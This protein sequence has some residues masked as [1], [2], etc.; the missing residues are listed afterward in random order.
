MSSSESFKPQSEKVK[1][2]ITILKKLQELG[3]PINE[4][5]YVMLK[6]KFNDWIKSNESWKGDIYFPRFGRRAEVSLPV[7]PGRVSTVNLLKPH[8]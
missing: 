4:P 1:E 6:G 5:G 2:S 8:M 7:E 3:I